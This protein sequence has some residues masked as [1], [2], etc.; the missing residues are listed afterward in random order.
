MEDSYN[1]FPLWRLTAAER[2]IAQ[3]ALDGCN[4]KEIAAQLHKSVN[5]VKHQLTSV[6]SKLGISDRGKRLRKTLG[7][8]VQAAV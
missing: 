7:S 2:D 3:L 6:Y 4:N 1:K 8:A 5:T